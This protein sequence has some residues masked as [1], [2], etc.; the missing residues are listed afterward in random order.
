M[1]FTSLSSHEPACP[2]ATVTI[3]INA[4]ANCAIFHLFSWHYC[5]LEIWRGLVL[6][7]LSFLVQFEGRKEY[8]KFAMVTITGYSVALI[9]RLD[10]CLTVASHTFGYIEYSLS[11]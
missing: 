10:S 6:K 8:I 1:F 4:M 7:Y 9:S 2:V 11:S 5:C 3:L